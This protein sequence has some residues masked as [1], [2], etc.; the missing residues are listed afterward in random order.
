MRNEHT[1]DWLSP[2]EMTA[3]CGISAET[4]R[5]YEREGLLNQVERTDGNQRRYSPEDVGWVSVLRCLRVT[6][7][8][9]REMKR[10][11]ELVRAGDA[12]LPER[13][14]LLRSHRAEVLEQRAALDD[15]LAMIDHKIDIYSSTLKQPPDVDTRGIT[16]TPTIGG[17]GVRS[18]TGHFEG[19]AQT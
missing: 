7:M 14:E 2:M 1:T 9:I 19:P 17:R 10:F 16:T 6:A 12:R 13:L 18:G 15:A 4:L 3:E 8:P 5:Y 11:A